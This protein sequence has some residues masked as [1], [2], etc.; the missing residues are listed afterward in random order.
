[1]ETYPR[2]VRFITAGVIGALVVFLYI[3]P[4]FQAKDIEL[5]DR[6]N[7]VVETIDI[8]PTQQFA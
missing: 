5:K 1:M 3:F 2:R 6:I 4:R 7:E 8:P